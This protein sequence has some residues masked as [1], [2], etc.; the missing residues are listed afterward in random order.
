MKGQTK[1]PG[2]T[3]L[4]ISPKEE[5]LTLFDLAPLEDR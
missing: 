5:L 2:Q 3:K 1:V 4:T